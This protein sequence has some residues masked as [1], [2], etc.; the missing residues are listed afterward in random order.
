MPVEAALTSL[1]CRP[2]GEAARV[3]VGV[4]E[5]LGTDPVVVVAGP[6]PLVCPALLVQGQRG[7]G[8]REL[9]R[10]GEV[11]GGGGVEE[12]LGRGGGEEMPHLFDGAVRPE[13]A[14]GGV[15]PVRHDVALA[16]GAG[17]GSGAPQI[18][19]R[20]VPVMDRAEQ[21][22][23]LVGGHDHP[24]VSSTVLH[25]RHAADLLQVNILDACTTHIRIARGRSVS[26]SSTHSG[27]VQSRHSDNH[28]IHR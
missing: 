10:Q 2:G 8:Q 14:P 5:E 1:H 13:L 4:A 20:C 3:V 23:D 24:A 18:G 12:A 27:H 9:A 11:R 17:L 22:A 16:P 25:Q 21:V 28:V 26:D 19:G 15:P 7:P 6:G